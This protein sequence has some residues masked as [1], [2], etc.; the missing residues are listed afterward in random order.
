VA[1]VAVAMPPPTVLVIVSASDAVDRAPLE[2]R[3]R[4]ELLTEEAEPVVANPQRPPDLAELQT[5]ARRVGATAAIGV[6][7]DSR[8]ATGTVWVSDPGQ[9]AEVVRRLQVTAGQ[10]DMVAVFSLRAVEAWRG[11][12]LELEQSRRSRETTTHPALPPPVSPTRERPSGAAA[13]EATGTTQPV[14][15]TQSAPPRGTRPAAVGSNQKESKAPRLESP[16]PPPPS[17][18][19]PMR[20]HFGLG[21]MGLAA[22]DRLGAALAFDLQVG[23]E[24]SGRWVFDLRGSGP[25]VHHIES[26]V[27][28]ARIDQEFALL[29]LGRVVA[30]GRGPYLQPWGGVGLSRYGVSGDADPPFRAHPVTAWSLV[31]GAGVGLG[32]P[33]DQS[34]WLMVDAACLIRWQQPRVEF[35]GAE[36]TR[37]TPWIGTAALGVGF[38]L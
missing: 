4:S 27:G 30:L 3:L 26:N 9:P 34:W 11:A 24:F 5:L 36:V 1:R 13:T 20:A 31:T 33:R 35:D 17:P 14:P 6:V 22:S 8:G 38:K 28:S 21:A 25:F 7:I 15:P 18:A 32:W 12:R 29:R 19:K 16:E 2:L 37:S 23:L 10:N